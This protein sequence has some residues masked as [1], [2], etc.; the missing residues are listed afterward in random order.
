MREREEKRE[1]GNQ[2]NQILFRVL[3]PVTLLSMLDEFVQQNVA[4]S[5]QTPSAIVETIGMQPSPSKLVRFKV[6]G[7]CNLVENRL[8]ESDGLPLVFKAD[9]LLGDGVVI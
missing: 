4:R 1:R 9:H 7:V 5:E 2:A 3:D 6:C 8:V